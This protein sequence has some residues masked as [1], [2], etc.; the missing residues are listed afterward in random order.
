MKGKGNDGKGDIPN[1]DL[2]ETKQELF[3]ILNKQ[4]NF[5]FD[6]CANEKNRKCIHFSS[7]FEFIDSLKS[8]VAWMNPPFSNAFNMF[9]HFFKVVDKGVA[10]YRCDNMETKVWQ[11]IILRSASWVFIP[12]GRISYKTFE[13][14][15]MRNGNGTR[16][17]SALIGINVLP[18]E[19]IEGKTLFTK[20]LEEK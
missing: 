3:N 8:Y 18:P 16:F 17:P 10:I 12:K 15:N 6:C 14:G 9:K 20:K 1:R 5:T 13:V 11:D 7:N 19:N 4:Y 2:W